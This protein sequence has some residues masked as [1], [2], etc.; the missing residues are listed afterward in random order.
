MYITNCQIICLPISVKFPSVVWVLWL[1]E[2]D[3]KFFDSSHQEV[4]SMCSSLKSRW[5]MWLLWPI[6]Y[7]KRDTVVVSRSRPSEIFSSIFLS[8]GPLALG[9]LGHHIRR[10]NNVAGETR[11][12]AVKLHREAE[13]HRGA[14]PSSLRCQDSGHVSETVLEPPD[15]PS[16]IEGQ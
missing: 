2:D 3:C 6:E 12:K 1:I 10:H 11:R 14:Q 7:R 4:G 15:R 8:L 5:Y 9:V 13:E 16:P